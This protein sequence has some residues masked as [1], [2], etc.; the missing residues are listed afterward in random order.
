MNTKQINELASEGSTFCA[1]IAIVYENGMPGHVWVD[2]DMKDFLRT[3][4][5]NKVSEIVAPDFGSVTFCEP[6]H[7]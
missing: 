7:D 4:E 3:L 2:L 5:T 1:K 6:T